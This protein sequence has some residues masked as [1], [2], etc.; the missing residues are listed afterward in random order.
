MSGH[1]GRR[2]GGARIRFG[3]VGA[4]AFLVAV[5]A[6]TMM[7]GVALVGA[8]T[9][10]PVAPSVTLT[11][12]TSQRA[13]SGLLA[14][15]GVVGT[16]AA[17]NAPASAADLAAAQTASVRHP[18]PAPTWAQGTQNTPAATDPSTVTGAAVPA[19]ATSAVGDLT[20]F[21]NT[22]VPAASNTST[23]S[24]PSTDQSGK[25]VFET[26]NWTAQYSHNNGGS[27]TSL[28]PFTMFGSGFCCDQVTVY[29]PARNQQLWLL[30][31]GN[32]LTLA[33][34]PADNLATWCSYNLTPAAL[35]GLPAGDAFDYNDLA[36][37]TKFAYLTSNVFTST[38][39]FV[40]TAFIRFNLDNLA[41]CQAAA[42][43]SVLR[44][45]L[46]TLKVAQGST[47]VA[48]A[49]SVNPNAGTGTTIRVLSWPENSTTITATDKPIPAFS[50][51]TQGGSQNCG[52]ADL[53]VNNWCK[54]ADTRILG[55]ARG[56]GKL[57]FSFNAKQAP[58]ARPF[59]YSRIETLS[60]AN[61]AVLSSQD[62]FNTVAAHMYLSISPDR[63]GHIGFVDTNGG[64]TGTS[65]FFP[66]G[67]IGLLDDITPNL[68]GSVNFFLTGSGGG[69]S[70]NGTPRW[71]DYNTIRG[72]YTG[73]GIWT[74]TTFVRNNNTAVACGTTTSM[75]IK[76]V[77]FGRGRSLPTYTR[78]YGN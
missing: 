14:P 37:G 70:N 22:T 71:G 55:A 47:D 67:M 17:A 62:L 39:A 73:T 29:D 30:Q 6:A 4:S 33:V 3:K 48:Y 8:S 42:N 76:N 75:T 26:S 44:T 41:A 61:L 51:M 28:N 1:V 35:L 31:Y 40:G 18:L 9:G 45:D 16:S 15:H 5:V 63:Q 50:V 60:E 10:G 65:H 24:E 2:F 64:G 13:S 74:A 56:N 57:Y 21:R 23:V 20:I 53:V 46:F 54:F 43:N 34:S 59:P 78:F 58:T 68:P 19:P 72:G 11:A 49:A 77:V 52:S 7:L 38:E 36:I 69:C 32:H 25:N 12:A 66:S 27:W